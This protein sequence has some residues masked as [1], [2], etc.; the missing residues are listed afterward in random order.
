[1][2]WAKP[3]FVY[4]TNGGNSMPQIEPTLVTTGAAAGDFVMRDQTNGGVKL[5]A[6]ASGVYICGI[7]ESS[8]TSM[9]TVTKVSGGR[10]TLVG[11]I[12]ADNRGTG[13]MGG[14][15]ST[16][17]YATAAQG[18]YTPIR[19]G[20]VYEISL[21]SEASAYVEGIPVYITPGTTGAQLA[22]NGAGNTEPSS[23]NIAKM[24]STNASVTTGRAYVRFTTVEGS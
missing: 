24:I 5:W 15:G 23:G 21:P 12:G 16:G 18:H 20:D 13:F 8:D 10:N 17:A 6:P 14:Q 4:N 22:D 1:M 19:V 7:L 3:R 9:A 2:A 11:G